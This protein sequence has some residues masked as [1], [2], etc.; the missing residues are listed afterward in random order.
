MSVGIYK[1]ENLL[2]HKIYIGQSTR[3]E[4]RWIEHCC[5]SAKSLIAKT[6][7]HFRK[8]ALVIVIAF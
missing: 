3:I 4:R 2:N 1:I 7:Q 8:I 5:P 6:I